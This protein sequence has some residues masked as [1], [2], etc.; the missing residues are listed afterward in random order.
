MAPSMSVHFELVDNLIC[1]GLLGLA[2]HRFA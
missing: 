2:E 1:D